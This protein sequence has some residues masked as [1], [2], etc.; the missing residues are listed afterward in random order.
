M[1]YET[2]GE[3]NG[4]SFLMHWN[5]NY[6]IYLLKYNRWLPWLP[7]RASKF[8]YGILNLTYFKH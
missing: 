5:W 7:W 2:E 8:K 3:K 4:Y 1:Y 6:S